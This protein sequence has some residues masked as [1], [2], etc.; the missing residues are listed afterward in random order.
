[1]EN[2]TTLKN[3]NKKHLMD[4]IMKKI[5]MGYI[6]VGNM[7]EIKETS[8]DSY[9][10]DDD[11]SSQGGVPFY[12]PAPTITVFTQVMYK[13]QSQLT[14]S[15]SKKNKHRGGNKSKKYFQRNIKH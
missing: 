14:T 6:P 10:S 5:D 3:Q 11:I 15:E 4:E 9:S 12:H 8:G 2:P 7:E 1:M 13:P